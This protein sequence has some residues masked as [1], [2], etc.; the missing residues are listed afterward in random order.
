MSVTL[1]QPPPVT[2]FDREGCRKGDVDS[3]NNRV[4]DLEKTSLTRDP[5][6]Q[7]TARLRTLGPNTIGNLREGRS[8]IVVCPVI[9]ENGTRCPYKAQLDAV[10]FP[11]PSTP[12]LI[13]R[14]TIR[15]CI[16]EKDTEE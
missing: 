5:D 12:T 15:T 4:L 1:Q 11:G 3:V 2:G 7:L 16:R 6:V 10:P 14:H 9:A 13:A 8:C